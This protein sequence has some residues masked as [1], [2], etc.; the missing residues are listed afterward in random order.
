MDRKAI[1]ENSNK[2]GVNFLIFKCKTKAI[3]KFFQAE[4]F[5]QNGNFADI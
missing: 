3:D 4:E 2:I 5:K 1:W